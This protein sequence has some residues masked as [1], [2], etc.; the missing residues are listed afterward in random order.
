MNAQAQLARRLLALVQHLHLLIPA[1]RASALSPEE[2][3]LRAKLE[4][5]EEAL[6][7]GRVV[8]RMNELWA[9]LGTLKAARGAAQT[10]WAVVDED[11]LARLVQ[12]RPSS[13]ALNGSLY[14]MALV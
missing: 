9:L 8:G 6:R 11:G 7:T 14:L 1:L 10:Q 5:A 3:A 4:E 12:V 2:E 13:V